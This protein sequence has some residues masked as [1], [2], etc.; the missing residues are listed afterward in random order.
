[1]KYLLFMTTT[2][3]TQTRI[4]TLE[5]WQHIGFFLRN[6]YARGMDLLYNITSHQALKCQF[7]FKAIE[8]ALDLLFCYILQ[9]NI[10]PTS[11][12]LSEFIIVCLQITGSLSC[13]KRNIKCDVL[14]EWCS[15]FLMQLNYMVKHSLFFCFH[16]MVITKTINVL[17]H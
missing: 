11:C 15:K 16:M 1:M 12:S 6:T 9:Q 7:K 17:K 3:T 5:W 14:M 13:Q 4:K 8:C 10:Q 2:I